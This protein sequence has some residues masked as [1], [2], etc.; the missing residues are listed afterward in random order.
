[1]LQSVKKIENLNFL[2]IGLIDVKLFVRFLFLC[3][4]KSAG[5]Y[6]RAVPRSEQKFRYLPQ[7]T[8]TARFP[9]FRN[10]S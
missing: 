8:L 3:R 6:F 1:M 4:T 7:N 2:A 9:F 5:K 10:G